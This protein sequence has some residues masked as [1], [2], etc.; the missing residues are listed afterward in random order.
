MYLKHILVFLFSVWLFLIADDH[1]IRF[2]GIND[3]IIISDHPD[4][5]LTSSYTIEA[6]IFPESFSWLSGIISKYHTNGSNGYMLRLS[7]NAPYNG[8]GFDEQETNNGV[9]NESQWYHLAAVKDGN[10]RRLYING[11]ETNLSGNGLNVNSNS[12]PLRIASDYAG[13]FFD[14]KIDEIRIWSNARS[15]EQVIAY[16]N[17][18]LTGSE[19]GLV[20]YYNF[21]TGTGDTLFD[22]SNN[23]HHGSLIGGPEWVDGFTMN[24]IL[25]DIN[26]DEVLNIYDAVQLVS[27][28]LDNALANE[29]Q[30]N[31]CDTNQD[32]LIDIS[33]V[34]HLV[35]WIL[36]LDM[37]NYSNLQQVFIQQDQNQVFISSSGDLAGFVLTFS[38]DLK[39]NEFIE[40]PNGWMHKISGKKLV[41]FSMDGSSLPLNYKL[42]LKQPSI[43][44]EVIASGWNGE[45]Q[46]KLISPYNYTITSYPNPFNN[47]CMIRYSKPY[48]GDT[49]LNIFD[50]NGR[51][52]VNYFLGFKYKGMHEFY[53]EPKNIGSGVYFISLNNNIKVNAIKVVFLK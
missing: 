22:L 32:G 34:I 9:L 16:M 1:A 42:K 37:S 47:R 27:I 46:S 15:E 41:A 14:G 12:D 21:N 3:Y 48:D 26:F 2:D 30:L 10:S 23:E 53:W 24:S 11:I 13:R 36:N 20:A 31:A 29:Q 45:T 5:D 39:N 44:N 51:E 33:D 38:D 19:T 4:L 43:I 25:G 28:L 7:Q 50:V 40:L 49:I 52:V 17:S 6:W 8:I 35:Q 18:S